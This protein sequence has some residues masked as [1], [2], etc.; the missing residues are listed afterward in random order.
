MGHHPN[1]CDLDCMFGDPPEGATLRPGPCGFHW[2]PRHLSHLPQP[3]GAGPGCPSGPSLRP[4]FGHGGTG[5]TRLL[6]ASEVW[7]L[8]GS[9]PTLS[10]F[11]PEFQPPP[12][13][14]GCSGCHHCA[15]N[16]PQ[17]GESGRAFPGVWTAW[18]GGRESRGG[19]SQVRGRRGWVAGRVGEGLPRC[20]DGVGGWARLGLSG[21]S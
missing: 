20:V 1:T 8:G 16:S 3:R 2:A 21:V 12:P 17:Q 5:W 18:V 19:P 11:I 13:V 10:S 14:P 9:L 4:R 15:K 6:S 7:Q